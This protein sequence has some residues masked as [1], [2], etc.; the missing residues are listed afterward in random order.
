LGDVARSETT[1]ASLSDTT[2]QAGQRSMNGKDPGGWACHCSRGAAVS[3]WG[4]RASGI[5]ATLDR[6]SVAVHDRDQVAK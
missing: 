4:H 1:T 6:P 2:P 5:G 3:Q